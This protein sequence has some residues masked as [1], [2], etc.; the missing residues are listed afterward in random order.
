MKIESYIWS[1]DWLQL[2][3]ICSTSPFPQL[4]K[5]LLTLRYR[6]GLWLGVSLDNKSTPIFGAPTNLTIRSLVIEPPVAFLSTIA[7]LNYPTIN[8]VLPIQIDSIIRFNDNLKILSYDMTS[9]LFSGV[10]ESWQ[11][12]Q[13]NLDP[14]F[15]RWPGPFVCSFCGRHCVHALIHPLGRGF[16]VHTAQ[17]SIADSRWAGFS[18]LRDDKCNSIS[19]TS[20]RNR[21][22]WGCP[23]V[24]RWCRSP[25]SIRVV[26]ILS[27]PR[28]RSLMISTSIVMVNVW[29][30]SQ[31]LYRS[32]KYGKAVWM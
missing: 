31:A 9:V 20:S 2:Q 16:Q 7:N 11:L 3:S 15:R 21:R 6:Y 8:F 28:T 19:G 18:P 32:A 24:L 10:D 22:V 27:Y 26:S 30:S 5:W 25:R 4:L 29:A 13:V 1:D 17:A 12:A 14:R 23:T